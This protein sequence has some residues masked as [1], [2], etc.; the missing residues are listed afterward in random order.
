MVKIEFETGNAAFQDYDDSYSTIY[1]TQEILRILD[2]ISTEIEMG[3]DS[4]SI[5]DINGNKIGSYII[6]ND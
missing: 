1:R 2:K 6:E 5:L 3:Y 4:N